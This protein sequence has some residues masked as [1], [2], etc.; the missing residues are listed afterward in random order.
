MITLGDV[1]ELEVTSEEISTETPYTLTLWNDNHNTFE[2]VINCLIKFI[3]KTPVEAEE[4]AWFVHTKGK[5]KLLE[6]SKSEL[7]ESFNILK[8]KGLTVSLD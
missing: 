5:H 4:I 3:H 8:F 1:K 2:H 7:I 6:G